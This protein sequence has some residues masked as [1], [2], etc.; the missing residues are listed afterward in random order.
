MEIKPEGYEELVSCVMEGNP[1][2]REEIYTLCED[3]WTSLNK[4]F[5][6]LDINYK[7][8]ELPV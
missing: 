4:W 7:V 1:T 8:N 2:D 6:E 5:E 3:L